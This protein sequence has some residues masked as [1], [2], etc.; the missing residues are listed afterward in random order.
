MNSSIKP[1][2]IQLVLEQTNTQIMKKV[3]TFLTVFSVVLL[4]ASTR[5]N[6]QVIVKVKP[7]VR[8]VTVV[9][10]IKKRKNHTWIK[11]HWKWNRHK[12][13]YVFV[14]GYYTKNRKGYVYAQGYWL[15]VPHKGHIWK[16]GYWVR[17]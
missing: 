4:G 6:A 8:H 14:E 2:H 1:F 16:K 10:P 9:K 15:H 3:F 7:H 17:A 12:N 13:S 5:S 11:P